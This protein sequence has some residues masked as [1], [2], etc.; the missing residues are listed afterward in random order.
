MNVVLKF[1]TALDDCLQ[2]CI[3]KISKIFY[4]KILRTKKSE[5]IIIDL[6]VAITSSSKHII[7]ISFLVTNF[8]I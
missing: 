8:L 4:H 2:F 7:I 5:L 1:S 6:H 3:L